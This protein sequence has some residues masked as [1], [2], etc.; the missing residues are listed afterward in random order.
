MLII[1]EELRDQIN[2][3]LSGIQV[4]VSVAPPFLTVIKELSNLEKAPLNGK[5]KNKS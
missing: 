3:F 5:D 1:S 4:P 2:A